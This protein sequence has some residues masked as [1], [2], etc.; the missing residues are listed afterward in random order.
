MIISFLRYSK[1]ESYNYLER[2]E[3]SKVNSYLRKVI[4]EFTL[5]EQ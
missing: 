2:K 5:M 1:D 3:T 4:E